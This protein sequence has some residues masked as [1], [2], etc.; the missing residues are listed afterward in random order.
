M[1]KPSNHKGRRNLHL[2]EILIPRTTR[3]S[4]GCWLFSGGNSKGYGYIEYEGEL[5][6]AHRLVFWLCSN[7]DIES[8]HIH[9]VCENPPCINPSHMKA[10]T[11]S[12]HIKLHYE[13]RTHSKSKRTHCKRG[14]EYN[15][16]NTYYMPNG[17][18]SCK[19]CRRR[20][21]RVDKAKRKAKLLVDKYRATM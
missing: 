5:W 14:H 18:P 13:L 19:E 1:Y 12:E 15:P 4:S 2:L 20:V 11:P 6:P 10:L 21:N 17:T 7:E 16:L 3:L 9:H 8:K